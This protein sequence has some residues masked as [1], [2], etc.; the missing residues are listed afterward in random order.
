MR[1]GHGAPDMVFRLAGEELVRGY[2]PAARV[3]RPVL[4][5]VAGEEL[6]VRVTVEALQRS[7]PLTPTKTIKHA[8]V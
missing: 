4:V 2:L 5:P 6:G 3:L 8:A 7:G 1:I